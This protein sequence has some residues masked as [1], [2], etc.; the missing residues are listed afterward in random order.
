MLFSASIEV[1]EAFC[2]PAVQDYTIIFSSIKYNRLSEKR[3]VEIGIKQK[4]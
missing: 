3:R 2:C 4:I 1:F